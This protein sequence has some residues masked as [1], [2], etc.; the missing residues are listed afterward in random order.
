M[1]SDCISIT[2]R[3]LGF[4]LLDRACVCD[5]WY[6]S[7]MRFRPPF[8]DFGAAMFGDLQA[9]EE[10]VMTHHLQDAG[11]LPKEYSPFC[12]VKS[13]IDINKHWSK[14]GYMHKSGVWL[15]GSPDDIFRRKD[16]SVVLWDYKTAHPKGEGK[17]DRFQLQYEMQLIGYSNIGEV[18]LGLGKVSG[19][20]LGYWD[21][22]FD[23]VVAN[24]GKFMR[25]GRIHPPIAPTV[26]A[27]EVDYS[28][29][30]SVLKQAKKI[31]AS[32]VPPQ[33]EKNCKNCK[34]LQALFAIQAGVENEVR[35][36]DQQAIWA[37]GYSPWVIDHLS[38][39]LSREYLDAYRDLQQ[40]GDDLQLVDA[41]ATWEFFE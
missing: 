8:S 7:R 18:G 19:A 6:L 1:P 13:R 24:P 5:F 17:S 9:I 34:K 41:A 14:Y 31:W 38:G 16:E 33:G 28:R 12:D 15:Y 21:I 27:V 3:N 32:S 20:A 23:E 37:S 30:D 10:A 22:R 29:L 26:V 25:D 35:V 4:L 40:E 36:R 2:P 39:R 11:C